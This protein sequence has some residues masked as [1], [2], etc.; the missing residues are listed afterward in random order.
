MVASTCRPDPT[1]LLQLLLHIT[2]KGVLGP[3]NLQF[4]GV[5]G[6][7]LQRD[8]LHIA[9]Q[10][11]GDFF[12]S[13]SGSLLIIDRS[14]SSCGVAATVIGFS[15]VDTSICVRREVPNTYAPNRAKTT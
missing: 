3:V 5:V 13:L 11:K 12:S 1:L 7:F 15:T 2:A 14:S 4:K 10:I 9:N 6:G 8:R